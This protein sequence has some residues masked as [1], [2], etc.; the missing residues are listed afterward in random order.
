MPGG[1]RAATQALL[2]ELGRL[3]AKVY[4]VDPLVCTA[5][6]RRMSVVAFLTDAFASRRILDHLGLS[7][8]EAEKTAAPAREP[9][10]RRAR[11]GL[12]RAEGVGVTQTRP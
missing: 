10:C 8:P 2:A 4:Q 5:C 3:I 9:A 7:T 6:G 1:R 11:R 12:G